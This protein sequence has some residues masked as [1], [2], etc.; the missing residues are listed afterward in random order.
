MAALARTADPGRLIRRDKYTNYVVFAPFMR[1]DG[2]THLVFEKRAAAIRQGGEI[3]FPGG[4]VE[5]ALGESAGEAAVRETVEELG[6]P[7]EK[8]LLA[9]NLG[10]LVTPWGS[11][12][13]LC[14][15]VLDISD[16]AEC[17]PHPGEVERVFSVPLRFFRETKPEVHLLRHEVRPEYCDEGGRTVRLPW[18][19]LGLPERYS[20]PWGLRSYPAW[21]YRR[22]GETIW[23]MTA[24]LVREI[25]ELLDNN[26]P[27]N[28]NSP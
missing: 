12:V 1:A 14:Y 19:E 3:C 24:D 8:V 13:D 26:S 7:H 10:I 20:R 16:T 15:G 6:L 23:G 5:S 17:R 22:D 25:L 4:A 9:G 27:G 18:E 21:F 2:E 28:L 11:A